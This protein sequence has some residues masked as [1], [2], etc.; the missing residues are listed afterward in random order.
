MR[1][2]GYEFRTYNGQNGALT[3]PKR[4]SCVKGG[5]RRALCNHLGGGRLLPQASKG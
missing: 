3:P 5:K 4:G 1:F 2:F